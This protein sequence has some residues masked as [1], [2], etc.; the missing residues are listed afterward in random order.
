MQAWAAAG[1]HH[2]AM[3][4][5]PDMDSSPL[6]LVDERAEAVV[7]NFHSELYRM[8]NIHLWVSHKC[9]SPPVSLE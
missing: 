3:S 7:P 1:N 8:K 9:D 5:M 6:Q 2:R 4:D